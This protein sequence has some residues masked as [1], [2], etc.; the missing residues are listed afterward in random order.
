MS[1]WVKKS[2]SESPSPRKRARTDDVDVDHTA[3]VASAAPHRDVAGG[4]TESAADDEESSLPCHSCTFENR[5]SALTCEMCSTILRRG[6]AAAAGAALM[7]DESFRTC[8][9]CTL[10]NAVTCVSCDACG[11]NLDAE[12]DDALAEDS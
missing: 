12:A 11:A 10:D 5:T 1:S 7:E 9:R 3:D 6:S 4:G 2:T 8:P